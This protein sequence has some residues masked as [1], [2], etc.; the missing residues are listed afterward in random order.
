MRMF[1]W[2]ASPLT[3][4]QESFVDMVQEQ[5]DAVRK[6][7][8]S[9]ESLVQKLDLKKFRADMV[10]SLESGVSKMVEES[11]ARVTKQAD[12][13]RKQVGDISLV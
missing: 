4:L 9:A 3:P 1:L 12:E 2:Q 11:A 5:M 6:H 7:V 13:L 8:S 10:S